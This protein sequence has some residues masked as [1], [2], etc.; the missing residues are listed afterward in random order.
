[1][2]MTAALAA[3]SLFV[4]PAA[5]HAAEANS[6]S[7]DQLTGSA[8]LEYASARIEGVPAL[9]GENYDPDPER[10]QRAG[11]T[12]L[13]SD[14]ALRAFTPV[15]LSREALCGL[16]AEAA[17]QHDLPLVFFAR[18]IWQESKFNRWAVSHAG[19]Q[20][21]AQFMPRTAAEMGLADPF[22]P[23]QALPMSARLLS[24]LNRQFGSWGLAAAAYNA[25][26]RRIQE[27]LEARGKLPKETRNYVQTIT[28]VAPENWLTTES[29]TVELTSHRVPCDKLPDAE[30]HALA[31]TVP[32][33]A[34]VRAA[35]KRVAGKP[36]EKQASLKARAGTERAES[37]KARS[38][39]K[40][41]GVLLA[42]HWSEKQALAGFAR[43]RQRHP[44]ILGA[45]S[46]IVVEGNRLGARGAARKSVQVSLDTRA[47]A[48]RLCAQ[49]K[50]AGGACIVQ[51][52][53]AG[54]PT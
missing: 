5:A 13:P 31:P 4:L 33:P 40:P 38:A 24:A 15:T 8:S 29:H 45:V 52:S 36:T 11:W 9:R 16:L 53:R 37:A 18:L 44:R 51:R 17:A 2:R 27:W 42:A 20:G 48:Q 7:L 25:G 1:M 3:L 54:R 46:P 26:A 35:E 41:W 6:T 47:D 22:D 23:L 43:L 39:T 14:R 49:I 32:L 50:S 34:V 21:V 12:Q 30:V 28:G 10:L 19:A